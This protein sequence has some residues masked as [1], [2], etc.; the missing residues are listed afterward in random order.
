MSVLDVSGGV[1]CRWKGYAWDLWYSAQGCAW[2]DSVCVEVGHAF[3]VFSRRIQCSMIM[4][5]CL[6]LL[7]CDYLYQTLKSPPLALHPRMPP[8]ALRASAL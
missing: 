4:S 7:L 6:Y 3:A 1:C 2:H 8:S 5:P